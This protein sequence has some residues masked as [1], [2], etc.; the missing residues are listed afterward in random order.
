MYNLIK[1]LF[2]LLTPQQRH[3]FYTLQVLV[4]LMAFTEVL[5]VASIGPFMALV[6]DISL[7]EHNGLLQQAYQISGLIDPMGFL[8]FLGFAVLFTLGFSSL[9]SIYTIWKLSLFAA[10]TGTE[11]ADRLYSHYMEQEWLFHASGSS[12]QL[13]K[14]ISIEAIRVTDSIIQPMMQ[15]NA[16][17]VLILFISISIFL[18][19]PLVSLTGLALFLFAYVLLFKIVKARLSRNGSAMSDLMMQRFKLMNEGFGGIKDILLLNRKDSLISRFKGTGRGF[20]K[21]RGENVALTQVPRYFMELLA[22][23]VLVVLILVLIKKSDGD[24]GQVLSML[25]IYALATM[26]LLPALQIVY[27]SLAQVKGSSAAFES[28][29]KD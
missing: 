20:A 23:G 2:S 29:K 6:G 13:T 26:K 12:A 15:M 5:A 7:I 18:Y 8:Y 19:D 25:A 3:K 21:A 24:L 16:R 14:Q 10:K 28:I 9:L 27:S 22:Y 11:I 1:E 4:V 17:I